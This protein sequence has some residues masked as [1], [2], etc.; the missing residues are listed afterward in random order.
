MKKGKRNVTI[1]LIPVLGAIILIS[2]ITNK[3][4]IIQA[5][6][7]HKDQIL[8]DFIIGRVEATVEE[9]D[10]QGNGQIMKPGEEIIKNPKLSNTGE[11][12]SYI[13]AQVYVPITKDLKYVDDNEKIIVPSEEMEVIKYKTNLGWQL[14]YED[15]FSGVVED[16]NGNK[17]KVYTYR[18]VENGKEKVIEPEGEIET[19]VFN[20]IK[21]INYL[22]T[23]KSINLKLIVK[24]IAIQAEGG[25]AEEMWTYYKNQNKTGIV[26]VN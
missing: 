11:I 5:Y 3:K 20:T 24:A 16:S 4:S 25:T 18:Y 9:P 2:L 23:D 8:N 14:V 12:Q 22:D 19:P 13:R 17:Y 6:Y 26:G 15:D 10:Y 7:T 1:F 21:V